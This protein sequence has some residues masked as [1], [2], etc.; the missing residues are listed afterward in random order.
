MH[1]SEAVTA[2]LSYLQ[3]EKRFSEHTIIAYQTDL[4]QFSTFLEKQLDI[5]IL[6]EISPGFVRTWMAQLKDTGITSRSI[7]RKGSSLKSFYRYLRKQGIVEVS[8]M[9][10]LSMP[11][12][13][14]RLPTWVETSQLDKLWEAGVFPETHD[15]KTAALAITILYETG[16]RRSELVGL[17][18]TQLDFGNGTLR[19]LGK[20]K[21]ERILPVGKPLMAAIKQYIKDKEG[22]PAHA[23][24]HLLVRETGK[25]VTAAWI[26]STVTHYLGLVT[27]QQKRSPHVLRHSFATHLTNAGADLNAVKELLGHSSLAATQVYTHNSIEKL[28]KVHGQAHPKG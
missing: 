8:P 1:L 9:A 25:P 11:R 15:G 3:F 22:L 6:D 28:K 27:T 20:G 13:P 16:I 24:G 7:H 10:T 4:E 23:A 18:H 2:F 17:M 26:Y 12:Q 21:K 14:K 5:K 19:V